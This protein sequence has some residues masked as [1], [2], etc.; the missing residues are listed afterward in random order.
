MRCQE[1][2]TAADEEDRG[3]GELL[4]LAKDTGLSFHSRVVSKKMS[5][6]MTTCW[7]HLHLLDVASRMLKTSE[8]VVSRKPRLRMSLKV[9]VGRKKS[10]RCSGLLVFITRFQ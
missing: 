6:K 1:G 2:V 8:L 7:S 9:V 4:G 3:E 10:L 5:F